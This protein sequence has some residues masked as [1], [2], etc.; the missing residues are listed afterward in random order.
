MSAI[1][2]VVQADATHEHQDDA[3]KLLELAQCAHDQYLAADHTKQAN[4]VSAV[5]SNLLFDGVTV[6]PTYRKP[7]DAL[8]AEGQS[9]EWQAAGYECRTRLGLLK[10]P[11]AAQIQQ[12]D[13]MLVA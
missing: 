5:C 12:F 10:P 6:T 8:V 4:I 2:L 3:L 1:Q 9:A 13:T 7:F 11:E